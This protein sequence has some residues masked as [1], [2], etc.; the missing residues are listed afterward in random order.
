M[1][2][3]GTLHTSVKNTYQTKIVDREWRGEVG[4]RGRGCLFQIVRQAAILVNR[5]GSGGRGLVV[6]HFRQRAQK[7]LIRRPV[8]VRSSRSALGTA[9]KATIIQ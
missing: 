1:V 5:V 3:N 8:I 2:P 7:T 9:A 6:E 4:A